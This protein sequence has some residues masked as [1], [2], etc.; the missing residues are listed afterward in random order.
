MNVRFGQN[1]RFTGILSLTQPSPKGRGLKNS[2]IISLFPLL[3]M[4]EG[5][6]DEGYP[7]D[8]SRFYRFLPILNTKNH[9]IIN[10]L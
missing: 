2:L 7:A 4:G 10:K 8:K 3:P 6:G 9:L 5:A 1:V